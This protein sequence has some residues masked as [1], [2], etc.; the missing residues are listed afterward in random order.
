MNSQG[1]F[2]VLLSMAVIFY[3]TMLD[4]PNWA[5][6]P[7]IPIISFLGWFNEITHQTQKGE[8]QYII[9]S[10][11]QTAIKMWLNVI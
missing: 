2:V 11:A 9:Y 8:L 10:A 7:N 6:Y 3:E 5:F 1:S 4:F